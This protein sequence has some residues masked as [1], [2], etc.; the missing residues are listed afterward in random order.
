MTTED[1][2]FKTF[3]DEAEAHYTTGRY[4]DAAKTFEHLSSLCAKADQIED[5]LYFIYKD[6][7]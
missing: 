5:M 2:E 1:I 3:L 6:V 7:L 4:V